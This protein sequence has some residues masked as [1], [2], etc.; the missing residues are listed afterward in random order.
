[1]IGAQK[2]AA[3][4]K[5]SVLVD[6]MVEQEK[7]EVAIPVL[8]GR[9]SPAAS[10]VARAVCAASTDAKPNS[11]SQVTIST[12]GSSGMSVELDEH[13]ASDDRP[14]EALACDAELG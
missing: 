3:P 8:L 9:V 14:G 7:V 2:L 5:G 11:R 12:G 4:G 10:R 6:G 1:M 13:R